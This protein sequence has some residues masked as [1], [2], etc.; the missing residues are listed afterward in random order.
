LRSAGRR[1]QHLQSNA[2]GLADDVG[3]PEAQ[4]GPAE[5]AEILGLASVPSNIRAD[6]LY[7]IGCIVTF[8]QPAKALSQI[9]A[10][11]E[12][13]IAEDRKPS[14][15]YGDIGTPG[16]RGCIAAEA[17]SSTPKRRS[18]QRLTQGAC[19]PTRLPCSPARYR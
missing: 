7:P 9:A 19:L 16:Q 8:A 15:T 4:D 17:K 18:E 6:L 3:F 14:G 5:A 10:M 12:I 11:P 1:T 13:S 2:F